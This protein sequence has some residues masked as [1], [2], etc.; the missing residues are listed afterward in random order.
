MKII[1]S[2]AAIVFLAV[3]NTPALAQSGHAGMH[4]GA[5]PEASMPM[6]NMKMSNGTVK[7]LDAAAGKITI[8]HGPLENLNMPSM[9]MTFNVLDKA[10]LKRIKPGDKVNFVAAHVDGAMAVT[11]LELAK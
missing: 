1:I 11:S 6:A 8:A 9:T 10:V 5:S 2:A 4:H 3:A 7:K